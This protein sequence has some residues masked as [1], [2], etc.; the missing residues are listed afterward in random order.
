[1]GTMEARTEMRG[2]EGELRG[3]ERDRWLRCDGWRWASRDGQR[4]QKR[5]LLGRGKSL[6]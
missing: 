1:M 2:I 5:S 3:Q 6:E 4:E